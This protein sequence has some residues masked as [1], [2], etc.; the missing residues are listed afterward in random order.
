MKVA[1]DLQIEL[2]A[3]EPMVI[4]PTSID[5]DHRGRVWVAEAVNGR[6]RDARQ[7]RRAVDPDFA[8]KSP[9]LRIAEILPLL[10]RSSACAADDNFAEANTATAT[11]SLFNFSGAA[12]FMLNSTA[13][14]S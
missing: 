12:A 6:Q 13:D 5:V 7:H 10:A 11:Q 14:S 1:D 2:F 4:N 9:C 3:A 8:S